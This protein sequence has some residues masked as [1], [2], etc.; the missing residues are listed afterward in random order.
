M[1]T[2]D[3]Y[4]LLD[5]L[6]QGGMAVVYRAYDTRLRREI[7]FKVLAAHLITESAFYQ[8]FER[9]ARTIATLEHP[10]IVPVYDFGI[11]ENKQPYLVMRLLRGGTLRDRRARGELAGADLWPPMHQVAAALDYAH[12][13]NVVHRDIKPVNILFDEKGNAYVS[14]F[15]I[16]KVRDT[17]TGDLTGNNILGTPAYM[18]PEQFEGRPVDGRCDQ[19]S[20]AVVLFEALTGR[21]PFAGKTP[22]VLMNQHLNNAPT[23]AHTLNPK[24]PP[25]VSAVLNRALAKNTAARYPT[26]SA[27]LQE[28]EAAS[29]QTVPPAHAPGPRPSAEQQQLEGYYRAGVEAY[30]RD[31]W[32]TAAALLGRV[33]AIDGAYRDAAQLR[34]TAM[35]RL[36]EKRDTPAPPRPS[37]TPTPVHKDAGGTQET[38]RPELAAPR[39]ARPWVVLGVGLLLLAALLA[40]VFWPP[41]EPPETVATAAATEAEATVAPTAATVAAEAPAAGDGPVV[42]V[43][44]AADDATARCGV[45]TMPL[46]AGESL[47]PADCRPLQ[48]TGGEGVSELALP[49]GSQLLLANGAV[50]NLSPGEADTIAIQLREGRLLLVSDGRATVANVDGAWASLDR[51]GVLGVFLYPGSRL[52]EAACLAGQCSLSGEDDEQPVALRAG[53]RGVVGNSGRAGPPENADYGGYLALAPDRVPTPTATP[54]RTPTATPTR[55]P[56]PSVTPTSPVY[57]AVTPTMNVSVTP[58]V[59]ETVRFSDNDQDGL[60]WH[61]DSCPDKPGGAASGGCPAEEP[62]S[63]PPGPPTPED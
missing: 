33:M 25:A 21:V 15:G 17:T 2:T 53:Q 1:P 43:I 26:V 22:G 5:V 16:A 47:S 56:T 36:Q 44:A 63:A 49:D 51:A 38:P 27:F 62:T 61:S 7:A 48:V 29:Y 57:S 42:A 20:L 24:L 54:T 10:S 19:Y 23:A 18:S 30:G 12:S 14:D 45:E 55:T 60:P 31:D 52:F 37:P 59:T 34:Q 4:Q 28:L 50:V 35:Q 3:R 46:A 11:D 32:G 13:A 8:R 6:G 39:N 40:Y 58:D 9:E 41:P